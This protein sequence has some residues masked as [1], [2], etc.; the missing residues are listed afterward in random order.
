MPGYHIIAITA[1]IVVMGILYWIRL[2]R[3]EKRGKS[4]G[5]TATPDSQ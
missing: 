1:F 5:P 4:K 2:G 3:L